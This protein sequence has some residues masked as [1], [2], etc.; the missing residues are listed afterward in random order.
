M[1]ALEVLGGDQWLDQQPV[2]GFVR[3]VLQREGGEV[4]LLVPGLEEAVVGGQSINDARFQRDVRP[5]G[6]LR[7]PLAELPWRHG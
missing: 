7:Q 5:P 2:D 3:R 1:R 4:D 6:P